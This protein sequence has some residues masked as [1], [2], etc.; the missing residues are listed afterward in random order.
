MPKHRSLSPFTRSH[1]NGHNFYC[2]KIIDKPGKFLSDDIQ[3]IFLSTS[4]LIFPNHQGDPLA[5]W[6]MSHFTHQ[7]VDSNNRMWLTIIIMY[8]VVFSPNSFHIRRWPF[9]QDA[10]SNQVLLSH[11]KDSANRHPFLALPLPPSTIYLLRTWL[12]TMVVSKQNLF[13]Q[14]C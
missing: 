12:L 14:S 4:S 9:N 13:P 1:F 11:V 10:I 5:W 7:W 3:L 8:C 2:T 6:N